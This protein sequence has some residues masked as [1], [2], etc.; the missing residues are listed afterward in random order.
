MNPISSRLYKDEKDFQIMVDLLLAVRPRA[1]LNDYPIKVDIEEN[2]VSAVVRANTRLWFD[3]GQP[4]GWAFVD[5][6]NNLLWELEPRYEEA[7]GTQLVEWGE[8]CLRRA[9][10][11]GESTTLDA[12]CRED[13]VARVAFL[14]E[15]GFQLT[16]LTTIRMRRDLSQPIP[17]PKLPSGFVIRPLAGPQEAEAVAAMH[18]AAFG[19]DQM[20]TEHRLVIMNTSEYDLSLDLVA[21][22]PDGTIAANCICSSQEQEKVGSTDPVATHP[23]YQGIGLARALLAHGMQLLKERGMSSAYFGTRGD[24]LA[25]QKTGQAVGFEVEYKTLWFSKEVY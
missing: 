14:N 1:Y 21:I 10:A 11:G 23:R 15:H 16:D 25:M 4:I 20:T 18:R 9:L 13:Y 2:L 19:T 6:Y 17:E 7:L 8:T 22:A 5:E 3:S 24:N 12:S